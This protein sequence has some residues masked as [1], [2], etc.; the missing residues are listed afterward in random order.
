MISEDVKL[1]YTRHGFLWTQYLEEFMNLY[2]GQRVHYN[3]PADGDRTSAVFYDPVS[4]KAGKAYESFV[5]TANFIGEEVAP[6]GDCNGQEI[7]LFLTA[8]GN[9]IGFSDYLVLSWSTDP[10]PNW[11]VSIK[12]LLSGVRPQKVGLID[13][14]A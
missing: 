14:D 7:D 10:A 5:A 8:S 2:A 1:N 9:L 3:H 11:R 12:R 13:T 6:V 4:V